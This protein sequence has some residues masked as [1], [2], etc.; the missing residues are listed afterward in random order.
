MFAK[1][2]YRSMTSR[3]FIMWLKG[4]IA[5]KPD[6]PLDVVLGEIEKM[7]DSVNLSEEQLMVVDKFVE[8]L[9]EQRD[10]SK[11]APDKNPWT[12]PPFNTPVV[13]MYGVV[14]PSIYIQK[15]TT[16]TTY[17]YKEEKNEE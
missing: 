16:T 1:K 12:P 8:K 13:A 3:E 5:A 7:A 6:R 9:I 11:Y 10:N 17:N 14:I 2:K 4:Y 15:G